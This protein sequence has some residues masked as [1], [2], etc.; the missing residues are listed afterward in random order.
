[1]AAMERSRELLTICLTRSPE[2]GHPHSSGI[3]KWTVIL[4]QADGAYYRFLVQ[5]FELGLARRRV[6]LSEVREVLTSAQRLYR[7]AVDTINAPEE[8]DR[9]AVMQHTWLA[10]A[11]RGIPPRAAFDLWMDLRRAQGS[12]PVIVA[13]EAGW[14]GLRPRARRRPSV[15][16]SPLRGVGCGD[17]AGWAAGLAARHQWNA[18][19]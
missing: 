18:M 2:E 11:H 17:R 7:N 4:R 15:P 3:A 13:A 9:R 12:P 5:C 19:E 14:F 1:M 8:V 6:D 16:R 10:L